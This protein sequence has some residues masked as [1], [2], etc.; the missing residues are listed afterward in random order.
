MTTAPNDPTCIDIVRQ[1]RLNGASKLMLV[2]RIRVVLEKICILD[3]LEPWFKGRGDFQFNAWVLFN[4][5]AY[6]QHTAHIPMRGVKKISAAPGR[7]E[8]AINTCVFDGF[9]ADSDSM[10]FGIRAVEKNTY[11]PDN[12]LAGFHRQFAGPPQTWAGAYAPKDEAVVSGAKAI[13]DWMVWYR[14]ESIPIL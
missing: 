9:V 3:N 4:D 12:R 5:D 14:V 2:S 11:D 10:T 13:K 8:W 6:R 7:N 1:A